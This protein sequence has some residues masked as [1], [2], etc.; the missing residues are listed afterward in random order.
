[1]SSPTTLDVTEGL[2]LEGTLSIVTGATSG[3]GLECARVLALRGSRVLVPCRDL[4]KGARVAARI[5]SGHGSEVA[6]RY[7]PRPCDLTSMESVRTFAAEIERNGERVD[8]LVANAGIFNQPFLV[9]EEGLEMTAAANYLGHFLMVAELLR[10]G[11]FAPIARVVVTQSEGYMHPFAKVDLELLAHP[12]E[13][14]SRFSRSR[15]S[16]VSKVLLALMTVEFTRRAREANRTGLTMNG[17]CPR[18]ALT[19]NMDQ[20]GSVMRGLGNFFAPLLF[21]PIEIAAA[22]LVWAATS[23]ELAEVS[24]EILSN[25]FKVAKP[26]SR[27]TDPAAARAAWDATTALLGIDDPFSAASSGR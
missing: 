22:P 14:R 25:R 27:C 23:P 26:P 24:G 19:A 3:L 10:S 1:M 2:S 18:S 7:E 16:P 6:A 11:C 15:A 5:S 4:D 8:R 17:V 12:A 9:T 21:S 13:H 20:V